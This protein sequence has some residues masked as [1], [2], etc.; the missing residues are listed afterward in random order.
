MVPGV[1]CVVARRCALAAR[2]CIAGMVCLLA[3]TATVA[4]AGAD[5]IYGINDDNA[6]WMW[7]A[8]AAQLSPMPP[9]YVGVA[10]HTDCGGT[11]PPFGAVHP[12]QPLLATLLGP[13]AKNSP[14]LTDDGIAAYAQVAR[15]LVLAYPSIRALQVWNEPDLCWFPCY[16]AERKPR[17]QGWFLH[18]YLDLLA[19]TYDAVAGTGVAVLGF[20]MSPR[21]GSKW[22]PEGLARE[23]V[24][25]YG[26]TGRTR[27]VMDGFAWH[28]YCNYRET[29]TN[30]I[31]AAFDQAWTPRTKRYDLDARPLPQQ[32]PSRGLKIWWTETGLDTGRVAGDH[33]YTGVEGGITACA[34]GSESLQARRVAAVAR[35]ARTSSFVAADFNFLLTDQANLAYWQTG[36]Y[37]PDGTSKPALAA[38]VDAITE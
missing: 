25:W 7:P 26:A 19:A 3:S 30:R 10:L 36:F 18:R 38:F 34:H 17:F 21:I 6:R 29:T 14:C 13:G 28:P 16:G 2:F 22:S 24:D 37:R 4:H 33:G 27:P 23:V 5:V 11:V 20:G 12:A 9:L 35:A 1:W 32:S 31:V 8:F 15:E